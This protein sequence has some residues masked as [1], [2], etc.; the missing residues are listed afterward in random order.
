MPTSIRNRPDRSYCPDLS[1]RAE[2][3]AAGKNWIIPD[4]SYRAEAEAAGKKK[5]RPFSQMSAAECF[6]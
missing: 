2:A 4:L 3:E 5:R 6:P 1:Y